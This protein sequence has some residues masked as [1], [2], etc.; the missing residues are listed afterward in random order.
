M[1]LNGILVHRAPISILKLKPRS[2]M[3]MIQVN[4]IQTRYNH[5]DITKTSKNEIKNKIK[6]QKSNTV[7]VNLNKNM[8][9]EQP[10]SDIIEHKSFYATQD[11]SSN[12]LTSRIP[13]FP[14]SKENIPTIL[15]RP[16]VPRVGPHL[17]FSKL[18]NILQTKTEPEVIYE[19]EPHRLY[20]LICGCLGFIFGV[21]GLTFLDW[22]LH[23]SYNI[24]L[25]NSNNLIPF[26]NGLLFGGRVSI[27]L[28]IFLIPGF[29]CW[30]CTIIPSRLIRKIVYVPNLNNKVFIQFSTHPIIPGRATPIYTIPLDNLVR[31]KK[32]KVWTGNGFYGTADRSTFFFMLREKGKRLPWIVDRKGFFWGDGRVFDFLFGKESI[33]EAQRGVSY[34][35]QLGIEMKKLADKKNELREKNG[36]LW[37]VK[38]M[39]EI[40]KDDIK[41]VKKMLKRDEKPKPIEV[42][43]KSKSKYKGKKLR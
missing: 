13:K 39:K 16:N 7:D 24:Y 20:F 9:I 32:T 10:N 42:K 43:K 40:V 29:C 1:I 27:S 21:Y 38:L 33:K 30:L 36:R 28:L 6:T 18:I 19:S 37:H 26:H 35:Q 25:E 11:L 23:E 22:S 5:N 8:E 3:K 34:D 2:I 15:P 14:L 4:T 12:T 17:T 31:G 41:D